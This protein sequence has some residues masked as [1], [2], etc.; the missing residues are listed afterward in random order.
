MIFILGR[1]SQEKNTDSNSMQFY[2]L[3]A[4]M[5]L[6]KNHTFKTHILFPFETM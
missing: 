2:L 3:L 1:E 6:K 5:Q 4:T